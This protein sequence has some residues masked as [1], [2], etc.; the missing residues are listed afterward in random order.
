MSYSRMH[1]ECLL[2]CKQRKK[3]TVKMGNILNTCF[4]M[5]NI[6]A[7]EILQIKV[8]KL[9]RTEFQLLLK[10]NPFVFL[11]SIVTMRTQLNSK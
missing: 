5:D 3:E 7:N 9:Y 4:A 11:I 1:R 8:K 6:K 2:Y 10:R